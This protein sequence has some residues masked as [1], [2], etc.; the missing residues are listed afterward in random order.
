M[1]PSVALFFGSERVRPIG[2]PTAPIPRSLDSKALP[3]LLLPPGGYRV[4][5]DPEF[6]SNSEVGDRMALEV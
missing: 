4:I 1:L 6:P 5:P 2:E 3:F